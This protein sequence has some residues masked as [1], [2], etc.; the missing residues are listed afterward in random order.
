M[1]H[2]GDRSVT[3]TTAHEFVHLLVGDAALVGLIPS[4]P[5]WLNEGLAEYGEPSRR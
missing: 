1:V 4:V 2:S 3:S 5:G